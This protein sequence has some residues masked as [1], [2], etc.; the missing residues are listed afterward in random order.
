MPLESVDCT[1]HL[2]VYT[3]YEQQTLTLLCY[4]C[5][6]LPSLCTDVPIRWAYSLSHSN[7]INS[8]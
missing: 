6:C 8:M 3:L 1:D 4:V 2:L 5:L 7:Q